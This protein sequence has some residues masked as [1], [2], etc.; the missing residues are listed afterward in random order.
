MDAAPTAHPSHKSLQ[1]FGLGMLD[2]LS[3]DAIS[4]HL[5]QCSN[6]R[7]WV[8]KMSAD[9]FLDRLRAARA[10]NASAIAPGHAQGDQALGA[11]V[12]DASN[13]RGL[14]SDLANHPDY[15]I[16]RELGRGGMG[17][18]YLAH[19]K[20]M[21]RDEVLKVLSQHIMERPGVVDRFLR[22]IRA[23]AMLR[24]PNI[25]TAYSHVRLGERIGFAMEYVDG[26]DLSRMVKARG[27]MRVDHACYFTYQAALGLHH[28]HEKGMVHRDIKPHNL[29]LTHDGDRRIVKILDFGV[30]KVTCE[31]KFDGAITSE[32]QLL[33]TP[34]Y[35]AP[36]Q[37]VDAT[38]ADIRADI[39]SLGGTVYH[40]LTG[41]AP[42]Q[43]NSLYDMYQAHMSRD[44]DPLNLV[45]PEVPVELAALVAKMMAKDPARRFQTPGEV[46]EALTPFFKKAK[47]PF[48]VCTPEVLP[49]A[50]TTSSPPPTPPTSA[51]APIEAAIHAAEPITPARTAVDSA[52]PEARW[53]SVIDLRDGATSTR[54][55]PAATQG[56]RLGW[57]WPAVIAVGL[58]CGFLSIYW[59]RILTII[60]GEKTP[61]VARRESTAGTGSSSTSAAA[62]AFHP[63]RTYDDRSQDG[64]SLASR[65]VGS[66]PSDPGRSSPAAAGT[67]SL[68]A[69]TSGA[70]AGGAPVSAPLEKAPLPKPMPQA[71]R[72]VMSRFAQGDN[73]GWSTLNRDGTKRATETIKVQKYGT[74]FYLAANDL[75]NGKEWGWQ[76]PEKYHGD[77]SDKFGRYLTYSIWV[78]R[79]SRPKSL[80]N[81]W[82][83]RLSGGGHVLVVDG[84]TL[85]QPS[86]RQ[87]TAYRI[88]LDATGGWKVAADGVASLGA[89]DDQIK[90]VLS[91]VTDL[92]IKGEFYRHGADTGC[93]DNV[94]FGSGPASDLQG[95]GWIPLFNGKDLTGW[96]THPGF[97]GAWRVEQG[98]LVAPDAHSYLYTKHGGYRDFH[99]RIEARVDQSVNSGVYF[100]APFR[101]HRS[102]WPDSLEAAIDTTP[103]SSVRTG[104]L[105]AADQRRLVA[106]TR[107]IVQ[108]GQW[109]ILQVIAQGNHIRILVNDV[110]TADYID[111]E[112][113]TS[114]GHLALQQA[115]PSRRVEFRR[116][117]IQEL[118][119]AK[120][121]ATT[122]PPIEIK[123]ASNL[124]GRAARATGDLATVR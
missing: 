20:L 46:A 120:V 96:K 65:V 32:G 118:N 41:H 64:T 4:K 40:L 44:A 99:L 124:K 109:F 82:H 73:E 83:V 116:I 102:G 7:N 39:Y 45:R 67:A 75:S 86:P 84:T 10:D 52:A 112:R 92:R 12:A 3:A 70:P 91:N 117:E 36:E 81:L 17:V 13:A 85:A 63:A 79:A 16:K 18:V 29:M 31:R 80:E 56:Q 76:A 30:A 54:P 23:V 60:S 61:I 107:P 43:A 66:S 33:G 26:L 87:W 122:T 69:S 121:G 1:S 21:G 53:A 9:S 106:F 62:G 103:G 101:A 105:I 15:E 68:P 111:A 72:V 94:E 57:V 110:I 58:L 90:T 34:D 24:H 5:D 89:T 28:A 37:I 71:V 78:S 14:P 123:S 77:H 55:A 49:A 50:Q 22:E 35:I 48:I 47:L 25:V 59:G 42:F 74:N 100:R 38:A 97:P 11:S 104:S 93:L 27:P 95:S 108:P 113:L 114:A 51:A 6:C 2:D 119:D 115:S 98:I 19:N 88:K 8:A